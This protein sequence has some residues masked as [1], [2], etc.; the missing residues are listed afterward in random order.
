MNKI[1]M[2]NNRI[3][4]FDNN[5]VN[6][7]DNNITFLENGNY[8][9][10]YIDCNNIDININV[11]DNI[12][13]FL[14]ELSDGNDIRSNVKYN[15]NRNASLILSKFYNNINTEEKVNIYLNKENAD[16]RYSFSSI[17][18]GHERYL[19]NIYHLDKNTNSNIFNKVVAKENSLNNFDI[20][21]FVDNGIKDCYLKQETKIVTLGDSQNKINPNMF[22]GEN[23]TTAIHSSVIGSVDNDNLFYLMTRGIDYKTSINLIIKGM[24]LSNINP[25]IETREII[26]NV[27]EK[28]GGNE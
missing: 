4:P 12:C 2:V 27:L 14:F 11:D 15:I 1:K 13:V 22:I 23:S 19:F 16:I 26:L 5:G 8:Y 28:L 9:I 6:I 3:I 20:N 18:S 25:D 21:S 7:F 10:E 24:I 17:S